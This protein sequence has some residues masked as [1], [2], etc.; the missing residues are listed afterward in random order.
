MKC[1][2]DKHI[3]TEAIWKSWHQ[4][5]GTDI[6]IRIERLCFTQYKSVFFSTL[7][8]VVVLGYLA[9]LIISH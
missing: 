4:H 2:A 1:H 9:D 7:Y 5:L 6:S 8:L 3:N